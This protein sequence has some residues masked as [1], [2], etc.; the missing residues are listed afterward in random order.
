[1]KTPKKKAGA[2]A[3]GKAAK[4]SR[5]LKASGAPK[6]PES[7]K[8]TPPSEVHREVPKHGRPQEYTP[9]AAAL[10]IA[11]IKASFSP[12]LAE[13]MVLKVKTNPMSIP[14]ICQ[15]H[16]EL[17]SVSTVYDW[18]ATNDEFRDEFVKAMTVRA[19][20][21]AE[22]MVDRVYDNSKDYVETEQVVELKGANGE[23]E[24]RII[25][26]REPDQMHMLRTRL[27]VDKMQ[28]YVSKLLPRIFRDKAP[29]ETPPEEQ[30]VQVYEVP[31]TRRIEGPA[32]ASPE[33]EN[34]PKV[35]RRG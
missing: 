30:K 24:K 26:V 17:P 29:D 19:L 32:K 3:R 18:L 11:S 28:W 16:P 33:A 35:A 8:V 13:L 14:Q 12:S 21:F 34:K 20:L 23:T 10:L 9:E 7:A 27:I 2:P 15:A 4:A 5:S 6:A 31:A 22:D 1:M 25:K